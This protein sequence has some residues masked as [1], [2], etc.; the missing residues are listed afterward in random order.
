MSGVKGGHYGANEQ[1]HKLPQRRI[2]ALRVA[3]LRVERRT[4]L[5]IRASLVL[6]IADC[7]EHERLKSNLLSDIHHEIME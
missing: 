2:D 4:R 7:G 6:S 3:Q 5:L 1:P